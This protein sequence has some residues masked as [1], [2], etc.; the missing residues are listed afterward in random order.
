MSEKCYGRAIPVSLLSYFVA[1]LAIYLD[2]LNVVDVLPTISALPATGIFWL[3]ATTGLFVGFIS[4]IALLVKYKTD[5]HNTTQEEV[6]KSD[7]IKTLI[8]FIL[9]VFFS[10]VIYLFVIVKNPDLK[11]PLAFL[12][13]AGMVYVGT[14]ALCKYIRYI[15]LLVIFLRRNHDRV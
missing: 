10:S 4:E 14:A 12:A 7:L 8:N 9:A 15:P 6:R 2:L 1:A 3:L 13:I 11:N 5:F